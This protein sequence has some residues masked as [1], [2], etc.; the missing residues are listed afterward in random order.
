MMFRL[1]AK[2]L[3]WLR[4]IVVALPSRAIS[5]LILPV[6]V[7]AAAV[8]PPFVAA[9][10]L[11]PTAVAVKPVTASFD[12]PVSLKETVNVLAVSRLVPL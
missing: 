2:V 8:Q 3:A 7:V 11:M 9:L 5:V 1:P 12:E 10:I 4:K 6:E